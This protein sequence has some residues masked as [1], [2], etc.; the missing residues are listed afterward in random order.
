MAILP[1]LPG[2]GVTI[3]V[4]DSAFSEY[5]YPNTTDLPSTAT[6]YIA[7]LASAAFT[8]YSLYRAPYDPPFPVRTEIMLDETYV[9][10]LF[11][12]TGGEVGCEGHVYGSAVSVEGG[13]AVTKGF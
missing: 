1:T 8:I 9:Q 5:D 3:R 10:A 11:V 12:E 7:T 6:K 13:R 4:A 2:L